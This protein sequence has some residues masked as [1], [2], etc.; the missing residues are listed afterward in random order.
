[1]ALRISRSRYAPFGLGALYLL[2]ATPAART[3]LEATM[4]AHML[5]QIPLL[6]AAGIIAGR[7]LPARCQDALLAAAG[8]AIPCAVLAIFASSYWMLPRALDAALT[9]PL[10]EAAKFISLPALV[11]LPLA[12]AW[13]RLSAIGRGFIWTNFISMLAVL[14]WLYIVAPVRVC[15]S[16][17]VDQQTSTGWL[18][19][20]FAVLLFAWWLSTLF[21]GGDPEPR[22]PA[23]PEH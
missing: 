4:S 10:T 6:A 19:V 3:L 18:M 7:L 12:L 22:N 8:G 13:K 5:V 1:M 23:T 14:G 16:Y 15:N 17:L 11:G 20:K 9:D 2:L 21:V